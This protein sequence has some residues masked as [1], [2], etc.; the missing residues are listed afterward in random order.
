M[1]I[2]DFKLNFKIELLTI[3]HNLKN[4]DCGD[5]DLNDFLK[6]HALKEQN[7]K[8]NVT[9]LI[10]YKNSIVGYFS[11]LTDKVNVKDIKNE[12]IKES[13]IQNLKNKYKTIPSVKIGR[14]A[15]DK[16]YAKQGIGSFIL[17]HL[18]ITLNEISKKDIGFRLIT[19]EGYAEAYHFYTT[20]NFVPLQND[21]KFLSKINMMI[22][23][24]PKRPINLILDLEKI[25]KKR[26]NPNDLISCDNHV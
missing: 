13:I 6:N 1:K 19:V 9:H 12:E 24:D 18:I 25:R 21:E 7:K 4:F 15:I 20:N 16:K 8:L 22:E 10:T 23:R 2:K 3:N 17:E 11:L 5:E 14:L 26:L